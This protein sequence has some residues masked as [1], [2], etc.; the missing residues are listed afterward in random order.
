MES[1]WVQAMQYQRA[2]SMTHS[3]SDYSPITGIQDLFDLP[4]HMPPNYDFSKLTEQDYTYILSMAKKEIEES[5][6]QKK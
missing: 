2:V 5:K 3:S 4:S 6:Q 1:E